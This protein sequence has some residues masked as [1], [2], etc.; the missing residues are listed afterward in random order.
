MKI[1]NEAGMQTQEKLHNAFKEYHDELLRHASFRMGT[2]DAGPDLVQDAFSKVLALPDLGHVKNI[3]AYLF[4]IVTNLSVDYLRNNKMRLRYLKF[5]DADNIADECSGELGAPEEY[6]VQQE[7]VEKLIQALQSLPK[8]SRDMFI[9]FK[10]KGWKQKQ[11]A[12]HYGVSLSTVEKK[13]KRAI[14]QCRDHLMD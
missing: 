12:R 11:I 8:D 7:R 1:E 5:D 10:S 9:L 6:V 14:K 2:G 13:I 3:R 4:R